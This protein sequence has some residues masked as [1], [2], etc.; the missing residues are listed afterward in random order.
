MVSASA[1]W[2]SR[3][4]STMTGSSAL[5]DVLA[6]VMLA[7]AL[8]GIG[9]LVA[10]WL[11]LRPTHRDVDL[12]HVL[13][14]V[15]MAGTLCRVDL[16]PAGVWE[17]VFSVLAAWFVWRFSMFVT[18]R[19]ITGRDEDHVHH[20]S[21]YLTHLVMALSMLYMYL[22]P[23][24]SPPRAVEAAGSASGAMLVAGATG[25]PG[26]LVG[27]P[28]LFVVVLLTS[29]VWELDA[30]ERSARARLGTLEPETSLELARIGPSSL[31]PGLFDPGIFDRGLDQA[32]TGPSTAA[33]PKMLPPQAR[34][35]GWL[36]PGYE[37]ASHI[38]MCVIMGYML[39]V[40][41]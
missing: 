12:M 36:A 31:A 13:M 1:P 32:A 2:P 4:S 18:R 33:G 23:G 14:G 27:V 8:Y 17:P 16:L 3:G 35:G 10:S 22:S 29:G 6:S 39:V 37:A 15:A 40:M 26:N 19:G 28:L 5:G 24:A 21:H 7:V 20:A 9:R 41:R 11:W 34:R 30:A 25:S 38:A